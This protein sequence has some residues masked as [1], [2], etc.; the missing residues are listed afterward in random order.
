MAFT[1][2]RV[3]DILT[4]TGTATHP[5]TWLKQDPVSL[6]WFCPKQVSIGEL[7]LRLQCAGAATRKS[8]HVVQ[9][10]VKADP[11]RY[12]IDTVWS[13]TFTEDQLNAFCYLVASDLQ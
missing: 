7:L 13:A 9:D 10:T 12:G 11:E 5:G 8:V 2:R 3:H 1:A 4:E 6:Q